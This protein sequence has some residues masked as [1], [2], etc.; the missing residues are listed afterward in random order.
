M[1]SRLHD[2]WF[3]DAAHLDRVGDDAR[4]PWAKSPTRGPLICN[5]AAWAAH[6]GLLEFA[7]GYVYE[8]KRV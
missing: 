4:H 5:T 3:L 7:W 8:E 6:N 2:S 1:H